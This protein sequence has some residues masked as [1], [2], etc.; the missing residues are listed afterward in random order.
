M[1]KWKRTEP[2]WKGEYQSEA[3]RIYRAK[4]GQWIFMPKLA[5]SSH[6]TLKAAKEF[7]E[8]VH[9][10]PGQTAAIGS[11]RIENSGDN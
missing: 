6:K 4:N 1:V 11:S 8:L 5:I 3:G 7:A 10:A 9:V 2:H